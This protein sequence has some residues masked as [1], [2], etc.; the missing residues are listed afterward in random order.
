MTAPLHLNTPLWQS[1]PLSRALGEPVW[2]KMDCFQPVGSFKI[3]GM[4]RICGRAVE[5]GTARVI[6]S[7]GGNAGYAIAFACRRLGIPATIVVPTT[8]SEFMREKIRSVNG[9]VLEHGA[10]WD[11]AHSRAVELAAEPGT[12]YVHPFDDPVI[13]DGH[14]TLIEETA[15]QGLVPGVVV[16]AV[17]GGGLLCGVLE[18]MHRVG[19]RDT[20]VLA[21]ETEGA[22]SFRASVEAGRLVTLD[23]ITSLAT[24][25]GARTVAARLLRWSRE[26]PIESLAVSDRQAVN[27]C[28]RFLDDHRVLVEPA[29]G[30]ALAAVYSEHS[31]LKGRGPVLIEICGGAGVSLELLADWRRRTGLGTNDS[32]V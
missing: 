2:M 32:A 3:R 11:D 4:G 24:T 1:E 5:D 19:W 6:G 9:E 18:G 21:V 31:S 17:G 7:S 12:T 25:L 22:A 15:E 29:C 8:T 30:A 26:H 23:A 14:A 28:L 20:P 27:A 10:S 13:W 16:V